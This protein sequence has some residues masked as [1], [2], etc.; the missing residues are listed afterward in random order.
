MPARKPRNLTVE[1]PN[2]L[3]NVCFSCFCDS[4]GL[5]CICVDAMS[6]NGFNGSLLTASGADKASDWLRR[7]AAWK[8]EQ[9]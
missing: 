9:E 8:A 5:R 3:Q 7:A 2:M 1:N 6:L 4:D